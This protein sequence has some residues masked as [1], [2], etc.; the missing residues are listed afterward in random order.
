VY[1]QLK[2]EL[3]KF[4]GFTKKYI[5]LHD[6]D[7]DSVYGESIRMN[8]DILSQS[9]STGIPFQEICKGIGPAIEEFLIDNPEWVTHERFTNN[10]G[11]TVLKKIF[12]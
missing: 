7:I 3:N 2:R 5:I 6:T 8:Y 11:L 9:D 4:K 12:V 10:N 1:G